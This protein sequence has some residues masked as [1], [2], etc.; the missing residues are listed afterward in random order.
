MIK[1]KGIGKFTKTEQEQIKSLCEFVYD[2]FFSKRLQNV[3]EVNMNFSNSLFEK[4]RVYGDCIWED[5]HYKPR[6]FTVRIDS[7]Q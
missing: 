4:E 3:L 7:S 5:Q 1:F 6:E 2:K